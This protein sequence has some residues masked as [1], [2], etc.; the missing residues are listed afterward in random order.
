MKSQKDNVLKALFH[1]MLHILKQNSL[2]QMC[3]NSMNMFLVTWKKSGNW[4]PSSKPNVHLYQLKPFKW[5]LIQETSHTNLTHEINYL[6]VNGHRKMKCF[7][8]DSAILSSFSLQ[9]V[10]LALCF[11]TFPSHRWLLPHASFCH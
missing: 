4:K 9:Y 6:L 3:S 10:L 2:K 7:L 5:K 8:Q 1:W 11:L